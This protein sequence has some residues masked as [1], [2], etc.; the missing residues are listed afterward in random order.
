MPVN[1]E[2]LCLVCFNYK[3]SLDFF[4][5]S[6]GQALGHTVKSLNQRHAADLYLQL[7][8]ILTGCEIIKCKCHLRI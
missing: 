8:A 6:E 5:A 1:K 2:S 3:N 7:E 4:V